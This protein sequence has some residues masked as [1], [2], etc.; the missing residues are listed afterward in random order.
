MDDRLRSASP[1]NPLNPIRPRYRGP[2]LR[3]R[4]WQHDNVGFRQV[5]W[6]QALPCHRACCPV[7]ITESDDIGGHEL[8]RVAPQLLRRCEVARGEVL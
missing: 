3:P 8:S 4:I 2:S 5:G 1:L 6:L 7:R